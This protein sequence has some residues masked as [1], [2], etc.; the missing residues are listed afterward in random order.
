MPTLESIT[1][2][3]FQAPGRVPSPS[4][5][6]LEL[7]R[8]A[9]RSAG[10]D[11]MAEVL[12]ASP[13]LTAK[14][15]RL[16]DAGKLHAGPRARDARDAC[17]RLGGNS[18][19]CFALAA[20]YAAILG[21]HPGL[22]P[23]LRRSFS[24]RAV[25]SAVAARSLARRSSTV[26]EE[27]AFVGGLLIGAGRLALLDVLG[28]D[29]AD[30]LADHDQGLA[31]ERRRFG[32]DHGEL[33]E[34]LL[35]HWGLPENLRRAV[36]AARAPERLARADRGGET[37]Q[38]CELL[39]T[40]ALV[41]E[42]ASADDPSTGFLELADAL[43]ER[44]SLPSTAAVDFL[45]SLAPATAEVTEL[46][47]FPAGPGLDLATL[48]DAAAHDAR[49]WMEDRAA[50]QDTDRDAWPL[51]CT[52]ATSST[53]TGL[54]HVDDLEEA[55]V[56]I[57][58]RRTRAGHSTP[59]GLLLIRTDPTRLGAGHELQALPR[60]MALAF[61]LDSKTIAVI[62]A[63]ANAVS[64]RAMATRLADELDLEA[65]ARG[66][67]PIRIGG[68][69]ARTI[70]RAGEAGL[71]IEEAEAALERVVDAGAPGPSCKI[72]GLA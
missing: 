34:V 22:D 32:F 46:L 16:A 27:D 12:S 55:L 28:G 57:L 70:R 6:T 8:L 69:A 36:G 24:R 2:N 40:A 3:L 20:E 58:G 10:A 15:I 49:D 62:V 61:E 63:N 18:V 21:N 11:A 4:G 5:P 65:E 66:E 68:A 44:Y 9:R 43:Q 33:D 52:H 31:S 47:G 42:V 39:N 17:R 64:L 23:A 35:E 54:L 59:L 7:L 37:A 53:A 45:R 19:A 48:A 29:Y 72:A 51:H 25:A 38:L 67:G 14:L 71:L 30:A 1:S 56:E 41:G 13:D 50:A 26:P 60:R